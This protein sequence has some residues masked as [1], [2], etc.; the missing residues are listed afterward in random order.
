MDE[1]PISRPTELPGQHRI[2]AIDILRVLAAFVVLYYH[3]GVFLWGRA[4]CY[5]ADLPSY[6]FTNGSLVFLTV[7]GYFASKNPSWRKALTNAAWCLA[8]YAIWNLAELIVSN[9]LSLESL[10]PWNFFAVKSICLQKIGDLPLGSEAVPAN[11]PLWFLRDL[12]FLFILTPLIFK[13]VRYL[14]PALLL[15]SI[16][17]WSC[18]IFTKHTEVGATLSPNVILF[19]SAGCFLRSLPKDW[20]ERFLAYCSPWMLSFFITGMFISGFVLRFVPDTK[21]NILI[22]SSSIASLIRIWMLYQLARY[23]EIKFPAVANVLFSLAPV[24]FLVYVAHILV[25]RR[26]SD[27]DLKENIAFIFALPL[28]VYA[29]MTLFFCALKRWCPPLLYPLAHYKPRPRDSS[30]SAK[31]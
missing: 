20:Q 27:C 3:L 26:V 13:H 11:G 5:I 16:F 24:S 21:V 23:I 6:I 22:A 12:I 15:L 17:P 2:V 7:S 18:I 1:T 29:A 19:F 4:Y 31:A 28:F 8:S 14:F 9:K 30:P 25:Y 10:Y